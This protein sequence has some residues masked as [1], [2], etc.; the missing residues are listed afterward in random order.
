MYGAQGAFFSE[1]FPART[2]Y[3]GLSLVQ[4]IGAVF[5]GGLSPLIGTL[6]LMRFHSTW[7]VSCYMIAISILSA[8]AAI[9]LKPQY[10]FNK[11]A[12]TGA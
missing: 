1:L 7:G 8:A 12:G 6:L 5:G 2:R 3:S 4:Q 9:A 11:A 10:L